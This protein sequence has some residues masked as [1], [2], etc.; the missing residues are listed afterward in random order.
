MSE[1]YFGKGTKLTVLEPNRTVTP[2][3]VKVLTP[4]KHECQSRTL[5]CVASRFYPDHV[6]VSWQIDGD[7][8]LDGVATDNAALRDG[9]YYSITSRLRVPLKVWY[10]RGK[11]FTCTVSFFNGNE[12]THHYSG[13]TGVDAPARVKYLKITNSAELTYVVLIVKSSIFG[14]FVVFMV[15]RLQASSGKQDD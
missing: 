14:V 13:I 11:M 2:P 9:D 1:A 6:S 8:I 15:W 5:V 7:S 10:T 4:S 3:T 12:T